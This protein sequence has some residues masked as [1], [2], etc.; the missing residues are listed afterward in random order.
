MQSIRMV[1]VHFLVLEMKCD[2]LP[3]HRSR[4]SESTPKTSTLECHLLSSHDWAGGKG[5]DSY[6]IKGLKFLTH[7]DGLSAI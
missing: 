3:L 5:K 1:E 4:D 6:K 7:S 2:L